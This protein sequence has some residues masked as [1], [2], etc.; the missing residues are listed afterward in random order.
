[1]RASTKAATAISTSRTDTSKNIA[2]E[3][4]LI[5]I[6]TSQAEATY[7]PSL[8]QNGQSHDLNDTDDVHKGLP[9]ERQYSQ[10]Q[11]TDVSGPVG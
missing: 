4:K 6:A 7:A 11:W 10:E 5:A 9:A 3:N 8:L 1:M 2:V